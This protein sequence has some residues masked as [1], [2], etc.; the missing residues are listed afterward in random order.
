MKPYFLYSY[1]HR[2]SKR[3]ELG[4]NPTDVY[5]TI[6]D[7]VSLADTELDM[8]RIIFSC[9]SRTNSEFNQAQQHQGLNFAVLRPFYHSYSFI[10]HAASAFL[11]VCLCFFFLY[12]LLLIYISFYLFSSAYPKYPNVELDKLLL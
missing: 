4:F 8:K 7:L 2:L 9:S 1:E 6:D 3:K 12:S 5:L 11:H 10:S